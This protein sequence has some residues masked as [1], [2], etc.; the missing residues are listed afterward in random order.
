MGGMESVRL[1]VL[2]ISFRLH[3]RPGA[4]AIVWRACHLHNLS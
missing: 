4:T 2:T 3:D 1:T